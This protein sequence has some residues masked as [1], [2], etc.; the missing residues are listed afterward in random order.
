MQADILTGGT[1]S[2]GTPARGVTYMYGIGSYDNVSLVNVSNFA[3][4]D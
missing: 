3:M 2:P 1:R 4:G